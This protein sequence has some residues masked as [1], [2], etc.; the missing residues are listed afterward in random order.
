MEVHST[1]CVQLVLLCCPGPPTIN[2]TSHSG[3][4]APKSINNKDSPIRHARNQYALG[5]SLIK[6]FLDDSRL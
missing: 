5:S 2:D 4:D 1:Y 6:V 3:L